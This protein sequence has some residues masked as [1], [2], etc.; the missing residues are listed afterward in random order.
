MIISYDYKNNRK[1][2]CSIWFFFKVVLAIL[3]IISAL[4]EIL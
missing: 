4:L 1:K 2:Y 3:F